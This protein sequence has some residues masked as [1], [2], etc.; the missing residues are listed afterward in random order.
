M[1][2]EVKSYIRQCH[3]CATQKQTPIE[4]AEL[5]PF[6]TEHLNVLD[7]WAMDIIG[8]LTMT[9]SGNRYIVA[10]QDRVSKWVEASALATTDSATIIKW[11]KESIINR[12]GV[13]KEL[14]TDRG[15][16]FESK[17][18]KEFVNGLDIKHNFG[19]AYHHQTNGMIERWNRSGEQL[20]RSCPGEEEWDA[21]L[22]KVLTTYRT[23]KHAATGTSPFEVMFGQRPRLEFDAKFGTE[24]SA[25]KT[26]DE[27]RS[28]VK[29]RLTEAANQMKRDYDRRCK[30]RPAR[31]LDGRR[32]YWKVPARK[33]KLQATFKGPFIAEKTSHPLSYRIKGAGRAS[34]VVHVNQLKR[35]FNDDVALDTLRDRGRPRSTDGG[36]VALSQR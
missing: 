15:S 2:K 35:C 14:I 12:F 23:T 1:A 30:A 19:A 24:A 16:Q 25:Q 21:K 17:E 9:I 28:Q 5:S 3:V 20:L 29:E 7:Q 26:I 22:P 36:V 11:L 10:A 13:P 6:E 33:T 18:F 27:T 34:K 32:V 31:R 4:T 8:P